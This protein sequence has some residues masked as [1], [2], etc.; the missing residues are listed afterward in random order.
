MSSNV[1]HAALFDL[2]GV[3]IDTEPA[4]TRIWE[5]IDRLHPTHIPGFALKI[6]GCTLKSILSTYYPDSEEQVEIC[7][8]LAEREQNMDYEHFAGVEAFLRE[9]AAEGIPAAIVT[10]SG[11]D[12]MARLFASLPGFRDYF[13]V[14]ITD[15]D[16]TRSKPD[17]QGYILA[18]RALGAEPA[19][20]FV[21]EDSFNGLRAGRAAG[22]KVIALSTT[23]PAESLRPL[24]DIVIAGFENFTVAGMLSLGKV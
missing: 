8:L 22:A 17:P 19:D 5:D 9:L 3:L 18:A 16:V 21:F 24:A 13:G 12:K 11:E 6:K 15:K 4:Y 23:N 1:F 14:V 7:R 20:C 2:D 10:S